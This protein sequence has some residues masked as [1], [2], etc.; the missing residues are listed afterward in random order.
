MSKDLLESSTRKLLEKF[1]AGGHKPGSG[2]AAALQGMLSAKLVITVCDLTIQ[3]TNKEDE[4]F[5][6]IIN[7]IQK[8][9]YPELEKMFNDDHIKFNSVIEKREARDDPNIDPYE[10]YRL[11]EKHLDRLNKASVLPIKIGEYCAKVA[12]QACYCYDKGFKAVRG[13]TLV[14]I[15]G[16]VAAV[17]GSISIVDLNFLSFTSEKWPSDVKERLEALR[18]A[19][20]KLQE[21]A[22]KRKNDLKRESQNREESINSFKEELSAL[23][24]EIPNKGYLRNEDIEYFV[25]RLQT[26]IWDYKKE[27]GY[28][29]VI[30]KRSDLLN[31]EL[32][33]NVLD[34]EYDDKS[35]IGQKN[36]GG[37]LMEVAGQ[38][39]KPHKRVS[40]SDQFSPH[41]KNF[42]AA[43]ELG[44]HFLHEDVVMHRDRPL[45]GPD[46]SLNRNLQEIQADK[47]ASYFMMPPVLVREAFEERF[48]AKKFTITDD[49]VFFLNES[50]TSDFRAKCGN[51]RGLARRIASAEFYNHKP[52]N[53]LSQQFGVS[54]EAMAIR[55]EELKLVEF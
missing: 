2:S 14:A 22:R 34:Y 20:I 26:L 31:P 38:I 21:R 50:N 32:V 8:N 54:K 29:K 5:Q 55:L 13:D 48:S 51:L 40:I 3:R 24:S 37:R 33:F 11:N 39:N 43:H 9:I 18:K 25:R 27:L 4:P 35:I 49:T 16:A 7:E 53:S 30:K 28:K 17:S 46:S 41:I 12:E 19:S 47:F 15:N 6:D 45:E 52:F 1:G 10:R 23:S 44:H 42:T 36:V